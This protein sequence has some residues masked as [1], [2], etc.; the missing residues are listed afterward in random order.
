METKIKYLILILSFLTLIIIL[1]E[2]ILKPKALETPTAIS[3]LPKI[4]INI[5]LLKSLDLKTLS[6]FEEISSPK[7]KGRENPFLEY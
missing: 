5:E 1:K 4:D 3:V 7:E 2:I 6:P